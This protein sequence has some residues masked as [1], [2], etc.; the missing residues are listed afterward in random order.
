MAIT[1]NS[2]QQMANTTLHVSQNQ[3]FPLSIKTAMLTHSNNMQTATLIIENLEAALQNSKSNTLSSTKL[4][5]TNNNANN[6][7]IIEKSLSPDTVTE[8]KPPTEHGQYSTTT[9]SK[10]ATQDPNPTIA[11]TESPT[12]FI[13][14]DGSDRTCHIVQHHVGGQ[15]NSDCATKHSLPSPTNFRGCSSSDE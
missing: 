14:G 12:P 4:L 15:G 13:G 9:K 3:S 11:T 1:Q 10:P 7:H 6:S 2:S 8:T 5:Q